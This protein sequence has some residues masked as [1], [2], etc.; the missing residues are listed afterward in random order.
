MQLFSLQAPT[1]SDAVEA[2]VPL[3]LQLFPP[4]NKTELV[5]CDNFGVG[6]DTQNNALPQDSREDRSEVIGLDGKF[7]NQH[8]YHIIIN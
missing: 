5:N 1:S 4:R 2:R 6:E 3:L 8:C 7:W